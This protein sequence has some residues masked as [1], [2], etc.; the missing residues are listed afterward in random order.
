M[1]LIAPPALLCSFR[2]RSQ[3]TRAKEQEKEEEEEEG[4]MEGRLFDR[5]KGE[6]RGLRKPP[7]LPE[8]S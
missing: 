6:D 7:S 4:G 3:C 1:L 2:S 5:S 8:P